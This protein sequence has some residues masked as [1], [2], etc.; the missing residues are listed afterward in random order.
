M[1]YS[2]TSNT[3]V[4]SCHCVGPQNGEPACPCMMKNLK[5]VNGRWIE[6]IDHGPVDSNIFEDYRWG[7]KEQDHGTWLPTDM[8]RTAPN[9][10]CLHEALDRLNPSMKGQPRGLSCPCPKCSAWC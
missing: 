10:P 4:H 3:S 9:V 5:K 1:D 8:T 7:D 2:T 6:T